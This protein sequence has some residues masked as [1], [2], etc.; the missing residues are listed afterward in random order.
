MAAAP[1]SRTGARSA[2]DPV[3]ESVVMFGGMTSTDA[4]TA[5]FYDLAETWEF[6]GTRWIR[7][8]PAGN[9]PGR[10][11]H[12]LEYD[13]N[14][15]QIVMFGGRAGSAL[16]NDTWAYRGDWFNRRWEQIE[17]PNS[18]PARHLAAAA[19]DPIRDRLIVYGGQRLNDEGNG[20]VDLF[21]MWEF[22]GTTWTRVMEN[23]PQIRKPVLAYD[24]A[25][26]E[27]ILLGHDAEVATKMFR[28][29]VA[30]NSW[31]AVTPTEPVDPE[32]Q[33]PRTLP[34]CI[35]ESGI[36]YDSDKELVYVIGGVCVPPNNQQD[37]SRT[38]EELYAWDGEKWTLV[39]DD[40]SLFRTSNAAFEYDPRWK[41]LVVFGGTLA[42]TT[43]AVSDTY[44]YR[45]DNWINPP[46]DITSP[47]PR[48]LYAMASDPVNEAIWLWGGQSDLV[49][50]TDFWKFQDGFWHLVQVEDEDAPAS[51]TTPVAVWDTDRSRMVIVC[52]SSDVYEWD[53]T[54]WHAFEDNDDDPDPARFR[55]AAYDRTLRK[56]VVYGGINSVGDYVNETWTW[57]GTEWDEVDTDDEPHFR[58]LAS[59]WYDP[60]SNKTVLYGG[61]GREDRE[62]RLERFNDMWSFDGSDW[63]EIEPATLPPTRYGAQVAVNPITN[64]SLLFGGLRLETPEEGPQ[65]QVYANDTW[66][67][68]GTTWTQLQTEGAAFARENARMAWDYG[69]DAFI[70]FGGWSGYYQSDTWRLDGLNRW[71]VYAE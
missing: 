18:P 27:L 56:T 44:M 1:S 63:T 64:R 60:I 31:V 53:G 51:C 57:N 59:M 62:G 20:F 9:L 69:S 14:R 11:S 68:N 71:M 49:S 12:V 15:D 55:H 10:S 5:R 26:N 23:G 61:I 36:A 54:E 42:Y 33:T 6:D 52:S 17:T 45:D 2:Y 66:E 58:A 22:D 37:S 24:E 4:A 35:N 28:Y 16:L 29:D 46:R 50:F 40:R 70:L 19:F 38:T 43:S 8:F 39:K 47:A 30:T 41:E 67:W 7:R 34:H 65:R 3:T 21:D 32:A 25:R 13:S 48:S